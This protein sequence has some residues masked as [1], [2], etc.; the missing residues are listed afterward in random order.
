MGRDLRIRG[1]EGMGKLALKGGNPVRTKPFPRWPIW[2]EREIAALRETCESGIWGIGGGRVAAFE[3]AFS[4]YVGTKHAIATTSG[5]VALELSLRSLGIEPGDEVI[6]PAYT[7]MATAT[8][9][10][11]VN[12]IPVFVD[13]SPNT[14]CIDP[15]AIE[16]AI[17]RRTRAVIPVHIGGCPADMDRIMGIAERHGLFV[18][19]DAAQAHGAEWNGRKVGSIGD[20]GCFS[21]QSSKNMTSGEGGAVTTNDDRLADRCWSYH[22]CGRVREG[23]WYEHHILGGNYRMTEFQAAILIPQLERLEETTRR[24]EENASKLTKALLQIPG[25]K[26]LEVPPQVTRHAYHL[27]IFRYNPEDF[28]GL[29]RDTF[30]KALN[31]EGIPCSPGYVPLYKEPIFSSEDVKRILKFLG[32]EEIDYPSIHLPNTEKACNEEGIWF[33][34]SM[35]LGDERDINDIVE[36]IGKIRDNVE[37]L[38]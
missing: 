1:E 6:V 29:R 14:Y 15:S 3:E 32:R 16:G 37:E 10:L 4:K 20:M 38:L 25:I 23:R 36:A 21:F 35:L 31:A 2:D 24:R 26:P 22:N 28:K 11:F 34:Q 27:Y 30:I 5:T 18:V 9:V 12:A 33:Y 13:I 17:T 19:E 7:F 8:S